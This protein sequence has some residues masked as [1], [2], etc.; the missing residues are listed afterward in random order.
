MFG[1]E[2]L[3]APITSPRDPATGLARVRRWLPEGT[4][5]D[6]FTGAGTAAAG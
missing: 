6:V 4:W 2:L 5:V 3:V 1:T